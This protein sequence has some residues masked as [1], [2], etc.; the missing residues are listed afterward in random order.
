MISN[1]HRPMPHFS[2][3]LSEES[4]WNAVNYLRTFTPKAA[5]KPATR[6]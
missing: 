6:P 3:T 4:R 1:G 2:N 5:T